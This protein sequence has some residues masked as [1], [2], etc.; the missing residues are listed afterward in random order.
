MSKGKRVR[1]SNESLNCY[2]TRVLTSGMN[3]EQYNR[4]PVLLYMHERGEVIGLVRDL[5]VEG[6]EVTGELVFDEATELSRRCKKQWEFG[7]LK[8]VSVGIDIVETSE[9]PKFLVRGQRAPTITKS[10]LFEV[11]LVD[12]GANDDAIALHK[13]GVRLTLGKDAADVLPPLHIKNNKKRKE[14]DQEKLALE[15]GLAKD[16]DESAISAEL[17]RLKAK[18][19]EAESLRKERDT[20]RA[21]RIETLVNAAVAEKKIGDDKK[22]QFLELGKKIGAEELKATFD[23][24]SPRLKLSSFVGSRGGGT[25]GGIAE[26]KKLSDVPAEE[27]EKIRAEKPDEYKRLYKAE[28]GFDCDI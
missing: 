13:D 11:S 5:K 28:Y 3:V 2:G 15:L 14:M 6:D 10:K 1:I 25:G 22:Q 26:Y 12:I 21:A 23:A 27:L 17:A 7:S 24:M 18:D 9:D 8:M 16:A 4:N 19:A 20:L